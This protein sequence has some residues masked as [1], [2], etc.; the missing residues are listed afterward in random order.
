MYFVQRTFKTRKDFFLSRVV[1][2]WQRQF[3]VRQNKDSLVLISQ[4]LHAM[5]LAA[6]SIA[7][8]NS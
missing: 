6:M 3:A 7:H 1:S 8:S 2:S 4:I 5:L